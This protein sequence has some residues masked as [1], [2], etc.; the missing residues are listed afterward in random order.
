MTTETKPQKILIVGAGRIGIALHTLLKDEDYDVDICDKIEG[1]SPGIK[2]SDI[3]SA[4]PYFAIEEVAALGS[5]M[6]ANFYDFT[7]NISVRNKVYE[8]YNKIG[9]ANVAVASGCGVAPGMSNMMAGN[10]IRQL[11]KVH[12]IEINCGGIPKNK[13][14]NPLG[15]YNIWSLDGLWGLYFGEAIRYKKHDKMVVGEL[16][17]GTKTIEVLGDKYESFITGGTTTDGLIQYAPNAYD[18]SYRT[19]RH[20]GHISEIIALNKCFDFKKNPDLFKAM[21]NSLPK[22]KEDMVV[23]AVEVRGLDRDYNKVCL[24]DERI[25][26][27][28]RN[29]SAM[30]LGTAM[31]GIIAL[32]NVYDRNLNGFLKQ[33]E[34][35]LC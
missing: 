33:E 12:G 15:Y 18:V 11:D 27:S 21:I 7:E 32:K 3:F 6:A 26:E 5:S 30:Q 19:V 24:R 10:L 8:L 31:G 14:V 9:M 25:I 22:D 35:I 1:V 4:V 16:G 23:L 20:I 2:Y 17:E 28:V 29:I 34:L 13:T